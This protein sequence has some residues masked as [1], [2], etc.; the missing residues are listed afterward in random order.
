MAASAKIVV[1]D[2]QSG[3]IPQFPSAAPAECSHGHQTDRYAFLS[4]GFKGYFAPAWAVRCSEDDE[5]CNAELTTKHCPKDVLADPR[6]GSARWSFY[7]LPVI[8]NTK[9]IPAGGEVVLKK[10]KIVV[11]KEK[12]GLKRSMPASSSA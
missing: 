5:E 12:K 11:E 10:E 2:A 6:D 3:K 8:V 4:P 7:M 9:M 1:F